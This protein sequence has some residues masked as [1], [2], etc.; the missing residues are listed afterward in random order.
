MRRPGS[1]CGWR[2]CGQGEHDSLAAALRVERSSEV[3]HLMERKQ[4][5]AQVGTKHLGLVVSR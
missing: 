3:E 1:K 5:G 4:S 2:D